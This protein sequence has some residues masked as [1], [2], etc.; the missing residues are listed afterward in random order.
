MKK[1]FLNFFRHYLNL[2]EILNI[3]KKKDDPYTLCIS[4]ITDC[5]RR[6]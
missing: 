4:E 2:D 5:E 1:K 6:G 3:L